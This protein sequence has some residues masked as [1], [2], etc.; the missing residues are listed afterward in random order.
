MKLVAD[1]QALHAAFQHVGGIVTSTIVRPIYQNVK[2][3]ATG[4]EV[5]LS[6]TDL[7]VGL[8][9]RAE[10]VEIEQEGSVLVPADRTSAILRATADDTVTFEGDESAVMLTS[11]DGRFRIVSEDPAEF[12]DIPSLV[13][14][15]LIEVD[16]QILRYMVQ[17]TVFAAAEEKGRYALNGVLF[18]VDEEGNF[19]MV[20]ADGARLADVRKKASNAGKLKV[21]CI[22]MRNGLEHA[23]RLAGLA[24]EPLRLQVTETQLL[25]ENSVGRLCCQLVEGQFPNFREVIPRECK[26]RAELPTKGLLSAVRRAALLASEQTRVVDFHFSKGLLVLSSASP[27]VGEAEVRLPADYDG[28]DI[29]IAFNPRYLEEMLQV[30]ERE[31]VKVEFNDRT[32]PCVIRSGLDYVYVVSPVVREEAQA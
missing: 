30:V 23:A 5:Y 20:A 9:I 18:L 2:L 6:A 16:P 28:A 29:Q 8:R 22:V 25:A 24:D 7:E 11:Q 3:D 15:A 1:R 12:A 4:G 14:D 19:E 17:R 27:D 32:S 13:E 26:F 10:K 21:D 31:S